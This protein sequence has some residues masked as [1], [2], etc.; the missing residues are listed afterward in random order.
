LNPVYKI[1]RDNL[2]R[3]RES[4]YPGRG[5]LLGLTPSGKELV[6]MYWIMGRSP[7]SQNRILHKEG[8]TVMTVPFDRSLEMKGEHLKIYNASTQRGKAFI[9]SNGRQTDAIAD[10]LD[11]AG[12]FEESLR[13]WAFEDDGPIFT[14]RISGLVFAGDVQSVYKLSVIKALEQNPELLSRQFFEYANPLP[15][16]GHCVH[17]YSLS[18][19]CAPFSGEPYWAPVLEG[20]EE[21]ADC[22]W[23]SLPVDKRVAIYVKHIDRVTG[24]Y[25]DKIIN[26]HHTG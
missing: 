1:A 4:G 7:S 16:C 21:N 12:G 15:G 20:V 8:H 22:Y 26:L 3:L 5:I 6:V 10:H 14:P 24:A 18:Q 2:A 23:N 13:C 19:T 9:V 17:T 11:K 25:R